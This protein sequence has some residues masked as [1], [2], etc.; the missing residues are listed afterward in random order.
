MFYVEVNKFIASFHNDYDLV[1]LK[2]KISSIRDCFI[3][4]QMQPTL[5]V[6]WKRESCKYVRF[7]S[8]HAFVVRNLGVFFYACFVM[9]L[10]SLC[11]ANLR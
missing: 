5:Q 2:R 8:R 1:T 6:G 7:L 10:C 11:N 9:F 4:S 3:D